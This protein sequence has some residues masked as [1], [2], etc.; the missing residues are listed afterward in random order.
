MSASAVVPALDGGARAGRAAPGRAATDVFEV[1]HAERDV[2]RLVLRGEPGDRP[3][4]R[5][6]RV[7]LEEPQQRQ[8]AALAEHRQQEGREREVGLVEQRR[9][10]TPGRRRSTR[11]AS[12]PQQRA[13]RVNTSM[14]RASSA[15]CTASSCSTSRKCGWI[16]PRNRAGT[17]SAAFSFSI[18]YVMTCTTASSTSARM[19]AGCVPVDRG[20]RIPLGRGGLGVEPRR[21]SAQTASRVRRGRA[22]AAG[23]P[24]S[25]SAPRAARPQRRRPDDRHVGRAAP[26]RA[27]RAA[28]GRPARRAPDDDRVAVAL[29]R[30]RGRR[31]ARPRRDR[32]RRRSGSRPGHRERVAPARQS[33]AGRASTSRCAAVGRGP[34]SPR[35]IVTRRGCVTVGSRRTRS[36]STRLLERRVAARCGPASHACSPSRSSSGRTSGSSYDM[37][38]SKLVEPL[39]GRRCRAPSRPS[40]CSGRT[41]R[42]APMTRVRARRGSV[43]SRDE[44]EVVAVDHARRVDLAGEQRTRGVALAADVVAVLAD[45]DVE[46]ADVDVVARRQPRARRSASGSSVACGEST[47]PMPTVR[48]LQVGE[49]GDR[50]CRRAPRRRDVRSRSVSRIAT[51]ATLDAACGAASRRCAPTPAA[52]ST[53]R[54]CCRRGAP[55]PAARSC[56]YR[57]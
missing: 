41:A 20:G 2:A 46:A 50:R 25:T 54:R 51:A 34:R 21:G 12:A 18:R 33:G 5:I 11:R 43:P 10:A 47:A 49:R 35:S 37:P 31:L 55:R 9:A 45:A 38:S 29:P 1:R 17:T 7:V 27:R 39:D 30:S 32:C 57:T 14:W 23:P 28:S 6:G 53:R 56:E 40:C 16:R 26:A 52:S 3:G 48:A 13:R 24:A 36:A 44:R 22:T 19:V 4:H 42:S 15:T 8:E